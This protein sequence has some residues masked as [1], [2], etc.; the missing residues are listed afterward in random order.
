MSQ[1]FIFINDELRR[2]I[3]PW[4]S[5]GKTQNQSDH[6]LRDVRRHLSVLDVRSFRAADYDTDYYAVV[7]K[8][9][10]D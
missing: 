10:R 5:D 4:T 9:G 1:Y 7:V 8:L 2:K 6:I 3:F